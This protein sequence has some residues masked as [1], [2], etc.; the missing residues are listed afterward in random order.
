MKT[1]GPALEVVYHHH[2][3]MDG[4][5]YPTGLVG[6]AIPLAARIAT[7][8]DVFDALTTARVYRG[9]LPRQEALRILQEE[10]EKGWWDK[11]IL[12]EFHGVLEELPET[13]LRLTSLPT[14]VQ[15]PHDNQ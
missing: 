13:D 1:L 8:A 6:E 4:S 5:G 2:E 9:A 3:R 14:A 11:R 12:Q 15:V 7:I 10:V